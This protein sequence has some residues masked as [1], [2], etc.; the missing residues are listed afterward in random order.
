M[1]KEL[2]STESSKKKLVDRLVNGLD[3]DEALSSEGTSIYSS[4][5]DDDVDM[6]GEET[7]V[8]APMSFSELCV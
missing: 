1:Q 3:D 8:H 2:Y 5:R 7:A 6:A 4:D